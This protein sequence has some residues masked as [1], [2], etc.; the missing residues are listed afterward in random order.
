VKADNGFIVLHRKLLDWEWTDD[1]K[2]FSVFIHILLLASFRDAKWHG[3]KLNVGDVVLSMGSL[4]VK[5]GLSRQ[6]VRTAI[7][8]LKSTG[9]LTSKATNRYTVLTVVNYSK[10]QQN[11]KTATNNSTNK[12]PT[13]NQQATNKQPHLNNVN[14]VNNV[15]NTRERAKKVN[16]ADNVSMTDDE[17]GKLLAQYGND[18][19]R[20]I[21]ILQNYK[22]ASG[23][24][25]AS[26]YAAILNWVV[27]RLAE[28]KAKGIVK[29]KPSY[30]LEEFERRS[31]EPPVYK[32]KG[33]KG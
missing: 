28:E 10:Y 23:K 17:Y 26:D 2:V 31:M 8:K 27:K 20:L 24:K 18:T 5:T 12:Q 13:S 29:S 32:K 1:C 21:E 16:Y 6:E 11:G 22:A 4:A 7:E 14:N 33:D 30:D 25:Y 3:E 9:E 19:A 15:N